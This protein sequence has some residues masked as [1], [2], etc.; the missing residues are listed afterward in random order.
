MEVVCNGDVFKL[1][2][3]VDDF[4]MLNIDFIVVVWNVVIF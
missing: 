1:I 3:L 4:I 2:N